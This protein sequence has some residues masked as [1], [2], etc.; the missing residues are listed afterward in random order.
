MSA[1]NST[2]HW[3]IKQES[4][5]HVDHG[6]YAQVVG[7]YFASEPVDIDVQAFRIDRLGAAPGVFPKFF[8]R[9]DSFRCP[10]Q[11]GEN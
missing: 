4:V 2:V 10:G 3:T 1:T 9:H 11:A 6:I 8:S 5:A 7:H